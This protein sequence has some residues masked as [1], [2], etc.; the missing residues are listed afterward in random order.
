MYEN[1]LRKPIVL[2]E[3]RRNLKKQN[4]KRKKTNYVIYCS[5]FTVDC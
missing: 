4:N 3:I 2:Y 1:A 5:H